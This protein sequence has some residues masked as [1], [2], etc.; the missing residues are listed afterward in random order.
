MRARFVTGIKFSYHRK[1]EHLQTE[2]EA[3]NDVALA[4]DLADACFEREY[5]HQLDTR[6]AEAKKSYLDFWTKWGKE[7]RW[8]WWEKTGRQPSSRKQEHEREK[9]KKSQH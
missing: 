7:T 9:A 3:S 8:P 4:C 1:M 5:R 6:R 2:Y